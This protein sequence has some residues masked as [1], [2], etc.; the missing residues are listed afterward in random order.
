MGS[1]QTA[2]AGGK[3]SGT[4]ARDCC[5]SPETHQCVRANLDLLL[6]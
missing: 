1:G 2:C 3:D 4:Q 5:L 6:S